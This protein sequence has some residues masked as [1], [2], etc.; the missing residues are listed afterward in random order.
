[1]K[2]LTVAE[3]DDAEFAVIVAEC[4]YQ[5][6]HWEKN[7][8]KIV[9]NSNKYEMKKNLS[10]GDHSLVIKNAQKSDEAIYSC[11]AGSTQTSAR[12]FVESKCWKQF[13]SLIEVNICY[14]FRDRNSQEI[15]W[16]SCYPIKRF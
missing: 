8:S 15:K 3:G 5:H 4:D 2:N 16:C 12:L 1:M 11:M 10:T 13:E 6:V 9:E 7:E 14:I